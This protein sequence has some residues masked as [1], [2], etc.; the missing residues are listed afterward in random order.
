M[1]VDHLS[2]LGRRR[3]A[4]AGGP[5]SVH[6]NR[7]RDEGWR[8][9]IV[10]RG[11]IPDPSLALEVRSSAEGGREAAARLLALPK[12]PDALF[13]FSDIVAMGRWRSASSAGSAC[14]T[15]SRSPDTPTWTRPGF[16]ACP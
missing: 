4:R 9:A 12:P 10:R 7:L 3:I 14:P 13:C 2:S 5:L 11:R 1:A 16:C 6:T 15:T 8:E